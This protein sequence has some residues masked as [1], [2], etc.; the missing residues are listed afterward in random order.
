MHRGIINH[1]PLI[2]RKSY[3]ERSRRN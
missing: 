1:S 2:I 3:P